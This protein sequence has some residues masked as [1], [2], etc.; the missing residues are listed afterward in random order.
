MKTKLDLLNGNLTEIIIKMTIPII[1]GNMI[2][3]L[4]NLTDTY[5]VS[6][7]GGTQVAA[8]TFVWPIIFL[9]ISI[10]QGLSI[11]GVSVISTSIGKGDI[12]SVREN[13]GQLFTISV[14]LGGLIAILGFVFTNKILTILGIDG[15]LLIESTKYMK[16]ILLGVPA[17]FVTICHG[18]VR[19]SEGNTVRPM[20]VNVISIIA[21]V[22]LNP[23]FIFHF[24]MGITGAAIATLIARYGV[25]LY[26]FWE[27]MLTDVGYKLELSQ[28]KPKKRKM[29]ELLRIGLPATISQAMTSIGFILL[30]VYVKNFGYAVLAA[31]GIGNRIHSIFFQAALGIGS[32][33]SAIV[34]QNLGNNNEA[35]I[36][37]A[38]KKSMILS[39]IVSL[40]GAII[41]Q[42]F[43][44]Q[45]VTIFAKDDKVISNAI[46]YMRLVSWTV[47]AWGVFQ[48][49]M[50]YFQGLGNTKK[51]LNIN[52]MRL[53]GA[54]IPLVI[55]LNYIGIFK[56]YSVWYSMF[57]S[58]I[59]TGIYSIYVY[60][61]Y[62]KENENGQNNKKFAN[63]F[64]VNSW[65][66][67]M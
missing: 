25:M 65:I 40:T 63:K 38:F 45:F 1:L 51:S 32:T 10:G 23:I 47:I 46:N 5:F 42:V 29:K 6:K 36:K 56:E 39:V 48:I 52:M 7:I 19:R 62:I 54:R 21:N 24:K 33:L 44:K 43:L 26:C 50:G 11:A 18:A 14:V 58:N 8:I 34:G 64:G 57:Y 55:I 2:Q 28:L 3:T 41:I 67:R 31:Y 12:K 49:I 15:K 59:L 37:E 17:T 60:K 16:L 27:L 66:N 20:M 61:K 22:L 13:I 4:Y 53:W 30:N 9:I 35:R